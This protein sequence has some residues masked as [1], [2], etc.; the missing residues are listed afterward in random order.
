MSDGKERLPYDPCDKRSII[1]YAQELV[2]SSLREHIDV[3][4]IPDIR[5]RKGSFGN[6]VERY[7]FKYDINSDSQ[8]DF[9]KIGM[10]LKTTPLKKVAANK[11]KS[12]ER[13]VITMINYMDIVNEAFETNSFMHKAEDI[14][15]ISYLYEKEKNPL[16]YIVE[17]VAEWGIP[18][19]DL[20][21][22][23]RDWEL[24]V[25]KVRAGHAEDISGSDTLYLEA[26][27]KAQTSK[28]RRKQPFSTVL[29]KPRAWALKASYMTAVSNK[30]LE[31][32]EPIKRGRDEEK[33]DLIA[34][35]RKRFAPYFGMTE[36][37]LGSE[38]NIIEIG[39]A[40]RV[41]KHLAALITKLLLGVDEDSKITEFEKAGIKAKT[42]RLKK[43]G[44]PKEAVSFPHF[45]YFE[46]A[47]T[48][49]EDSDF[50]GYLQQKY[51]FVI[52]REGAKE[53]GVYRLADVMLWQ[54]PDS[55]LDEA[56]RCYDEMRVRVIEGHA[57]ES[58]KSSENRCC[59]VRP[60]ARNAEDTL[61][62]PNGKP[63][64]KK[65]FWLNSAY[66]KDQLQKRLV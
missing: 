45:D 38:L 5:H 49:F 13:L 16:D 37:E 22:I 35:V 4:E 59:H 2:G 14:L 43:D 7:F 20:P 42:L 36:L 21:Q 64:V 15:L 31:K 57:D 61:P 55:D 23:K 18:P 50:F 65:C 62:V 54:M 39:S 32:M 46:L 26:C 1:E 58:V 28:D 52:Y 8:P 51:L 12:K 3:N 60:H 40:K 29:A 53:R 34:L 56:K 30:L 10:E 19:E 44:M 63:E 41:P 11:F 33:L 9:S 27:T 48:E 17:I 25:D 66:L 24:V 6:A 47:E